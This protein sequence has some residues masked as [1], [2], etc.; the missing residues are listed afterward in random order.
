MI[1]KACIVYEDVCT[2]MI[3]SHSI[4]LTINVSKN[5]C[6]ENQKTQFIFNNFKEKCA[7]MR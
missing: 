6:N 5:V 4:L 1:K 2:F 7:F 3:W